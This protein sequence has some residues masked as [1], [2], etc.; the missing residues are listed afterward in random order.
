MKWYDSRIKSPTTRAFGLY[1]AV[2]QKHGGYQYVEQVGW[3]PMNNYTE[4]RWTIITQ[5]DRPVKLYL[6]TTE[7]LYWCELPKLPITLDVSNNE[8]VL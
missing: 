7:L 3:E 6:D 1:L 8:L 4:G 5:S 2:L